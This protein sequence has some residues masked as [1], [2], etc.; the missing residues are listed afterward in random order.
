MQVGSG[1]FLSYSS[2]VTCSDRGR[3]GVDGRERESGEAGLRA[4]SGVGGSCKES[5]A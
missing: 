1:S 5:R 3:A 2:S 4:G